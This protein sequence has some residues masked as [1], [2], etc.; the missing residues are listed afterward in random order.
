MRGIIQALQYIP[1]SAKHTESPIEVMMFEALMKTGEVVLV[2]EGEPE[3]EGFFLYPQKQ[4]GPYRADF[5]L[6]AIGY[7]DFAPKVW[8]PKLRAKICIE[9]DGKEF[10]SS[11]EDVE[12]DKRR[13]EYFKERG[14]KTYR[15]SGSDI[16]YNAQFCAEC[17]LHEAKEALKGCKVD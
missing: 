13:D 14:I 9:C 10:H 15:Y 3:G 5:I 7:P 1:Y 4:V 12:H 6:E 17:V 11:K 8:P 2:E 16:N